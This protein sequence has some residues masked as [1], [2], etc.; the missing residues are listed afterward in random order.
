MMHVFPLANPHP[1]PQST[2][3]HFFHPFES[4]GS[5]RIAQSTHHSHIQPEM[6]DFACETFHNFPLTPLIPT[7]PPSLDIQ[8][9]EL[10]NGSVV[11]PICDSLSVSASTVMGWD[12][13]PQTSASVG[14]P[15]YSSTPLSMMDLLNDEV[16]DVLLSNVAEGYLYV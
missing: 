1:Q 9:A 6:Y 12:N 5:T 16:D 8:F 13:F 3:S 11:S 2:M 4:H 7:S 10:S 15:D 14:Y